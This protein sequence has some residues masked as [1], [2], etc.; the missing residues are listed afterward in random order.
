VVGRDHV[1]LERI[2]DGL[3]HRTARLA[4]QQVSTSRILF[5]PLMNKLQQAPGLPSA[6]RAFKEDLAVVAGEQLMD[7]RSPLQYK[8]A[9]L[10]LQ[11]IS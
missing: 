10:D 6:C 7:R 8:L 3:R 9:P 11:S 1:S 5:G 4:A 2:Q